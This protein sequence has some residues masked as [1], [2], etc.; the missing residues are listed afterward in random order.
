MC[1]P[2]TLSLP[3]FREKG[4]RERENKKNAPKRSKH[5]TGQLIDVLK[6]SKKKTENMHS[7]IKQIGQHE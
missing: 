1:E 7:L 3:F 6:V 2:P 5:G 4:E